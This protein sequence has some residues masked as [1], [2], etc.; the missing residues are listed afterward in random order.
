M[1]HFNEFD[2]GL[3]EEIY[4]LHADAKTAI[5]EECVRRDWKKLWLSMVPTGKIGREAQNQRRFSP[6]TP[7]AMTL[8]ESQE[9]Q[10][11]FQRW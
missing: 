1:G 8:A 3:V 5:F 10:A 11:G 4:Q 7:A 2:P 9:E 6:V